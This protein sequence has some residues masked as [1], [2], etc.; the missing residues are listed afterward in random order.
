MQQILLYE[1]KSAEVA[2]KL[3]EHNA[4]SKKYH[5]IKKDKDDESNEA[6]I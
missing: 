1:H 6:F 2:Q 5:I 3:L 4:T